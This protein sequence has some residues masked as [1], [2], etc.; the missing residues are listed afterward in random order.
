M[1][2][3]LEYFHNYGIKKPDL[4]ENVVVERD[5]TGRWVSIANYLPPSTSMADGKEGIDGGQ[6]T[7]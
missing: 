7:T 1:A 2:T 6:D 4:Q 5:L 3:K